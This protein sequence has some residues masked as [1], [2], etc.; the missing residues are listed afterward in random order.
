MTTKVGQRDYW[1]QWCQ[2]NAGVPKVSYKRKNA[3]SK[4]QQRKVVE[5]EINFELGFWSSTAASL[6]A[7]A[8]SAT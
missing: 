2:Y 1:I 3:K 8:T 4:V 6:T 5:S 7:H